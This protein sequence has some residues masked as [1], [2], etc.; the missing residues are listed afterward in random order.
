MS[1]M[2]APTSTSMGERSCRRGL[3]M[4][5]RLLLGGLASFAPLAA[6]TTLIGFPDV[7]SVQDGGATGGD[8]GRVDATK[9]SGSG[10]GRRDAG[11]ASGSG[12]SAGSGSGV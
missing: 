8:A 9:G 2:A 5:R 6:C 12:S 1:S 10:S 4:R 7:G 3:S 11:S